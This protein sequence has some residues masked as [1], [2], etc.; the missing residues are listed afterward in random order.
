MKLSEI[1]SWAWIVGG[2]CFVGAWLFGALAP[3]VVGAWNLPS[4]SF[5]A[6]TSLCWGVY[7]WCRAREQQQTREG[8]AF[9]LAIFAIVPWLIF[10]FLIIMPYAVGIRS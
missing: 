10:P 9:G 8:L 6:L 4:M 1:R 5:L 3:S 7:G 2:V